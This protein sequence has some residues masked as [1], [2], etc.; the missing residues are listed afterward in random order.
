MDLLIPL[1]ALAGLALP[2]MAIIALVMA[3]GAR[4]RIRVIER[5]LAGLESA[6]A[7]GAMP[8]AAPATEAPGARPQPPPEPIA[9]TGA[10]AIVPPEPAPAEVTGRSKCVNRDKSLGG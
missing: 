7:A 4:E 8:R 10:E 9:Q 1:V 5:R 6:L 2:I 3:I